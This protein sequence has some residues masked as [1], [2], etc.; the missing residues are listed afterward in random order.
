MVIHFKN[1][2]QNPAWFLSYDL[3]ICIVPSCNVYFSSE[4]KN[5]LGSM[6]ALYI[7]AV[8]SIM[9][10]TD[11]DPA[12]KFKAYILLHTNGAGLISYVYFHIQSWV[13]GFL[14]DS[15]YRSGYNR[16]QIHKLG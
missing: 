4:K 5:Q 16:I 2:A 12:P 13:T 14:S 3:F 10:N 1:L 15:I 11:L 9:L 6:K 8:D 7:R